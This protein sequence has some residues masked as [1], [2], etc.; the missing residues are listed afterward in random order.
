VA[1]LYYAKFSIKSHLLRS[2]CR[3]CGMVFL[4]SLQ[5]CFQARQEW[6]SALALILMVAE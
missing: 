3:L 6:Y 5:A 2:A 1:G 4:C